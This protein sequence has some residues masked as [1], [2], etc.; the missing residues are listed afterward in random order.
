MEPLE[1]TALLEEVGTLLEGALRV[2]SLVHSRFLFPWCLW[3]K[4]YSPCFVLLF[5][6]HCGVSL[7]NCRPKF[8]LP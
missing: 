3:L 8:T 7:W 1:G 6:Y 4:M 5:L 2:F